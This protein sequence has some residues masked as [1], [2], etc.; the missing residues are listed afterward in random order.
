MPAPM[1]R[2]FSGV[3]SQR[4]VHSTGS[5]TPTLLGVLVALWLLMFLPQVAN[6]NGVLVVGEAPDYS[7]DD[8]VAVLR[9]PS[10][11]LGLADVLRADAEGAFRPAGSVG[12]NFGLSEDTVWLRLDLQ[13]AKQAPSRWLLEVGHASLDRVNLHLLGLDGRVTSVQSG[14]HLPF[15]ARPLVHR[16]HV[17]ALGLSP[18]QPQRVYLQ[19]R[20][21]G[22][23]AV[24]LRLWQPDALWRSD[25]LSYS[26]LSL[27]FGLLIGLLVYNLLL[28]LALRDWLY[29]VYV[30]FVGC[31][32]VG[33]AGLTGFSAQF[34]WPEQAW[35]A[36][37]SPTGGVAAAGLFGTLF[38]HGFLHRTWRSLR[39]T[40]LMPLLSSVYL[41]TLLCVM[42]WSYHIAAWLVNVNSF[43]FSVSVVLVGL[44]S[45]FQRQPGSRFFVLAWTLLL[46]G[47]LVISLHNTGVLP[48]NVLTANA[49]LIGSALEMILLSLALADRIRATQNE[50]EV[51][52]NAAMRLK[53]EML[54][55]LQR[56]EQLLESRVIER[57]RA[58]EEANDQLR[59]N[60]M[61]LENLANHDALT[62]LAN[63]KL[64]IDRLGQATHRARRQGAGFAVL[65]ADL[66]HF[67]SVN[68]NHGHAAG[69][70]VLTTVAQRLTA[71]VRGVD[72]VARIG[73]DEFV[74]IL[75]DVQAREDAERV[76]SAVRS[77][78]TEPI[79][80]EN[81]VQVCV[82]VSIGVSIYPDDSQQVERLL[83]LADL[84][85]YS[86]KAAHRAAGHPPVIAS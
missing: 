58:L 25:Q 32:A 63:R 44:V 55:S 78:L 68:D 20:S 50:K 54:E 38:A 56:S 73:G 14:D 41:V 39:M 52:Q 15:T 48:S 1:A 51:A 45:L 77:S 10:G 60:E 9:D 8:A 76:A 16:N 62:G 80:L 61:H 75:E 6:A 19:V 65:V 11:E 43:L 30:C 86:A 4:E 23:L 79:V 18:E 67:K 33:Q 46:T 29:I 59:R 34:L 26:L 71:A 3:S 66:D 37:V 69:D 70:R 24:P 21:T 35:W 42:F 40:W 31:L 22:T 17:F 12:T 64:L 28:Y 82:G 57:T 83:S 2:F 47:A 27:Y 49:L 5:A 13:A 84:Q 7:L 74:L 36:N 85:M 53:Q 81:G 72:T